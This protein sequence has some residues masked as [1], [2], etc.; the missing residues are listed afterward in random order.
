MNM[1]I[2]IKAILYNYYV[3]IQDNVDKKNIITL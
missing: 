2:R 1:V 3:Q